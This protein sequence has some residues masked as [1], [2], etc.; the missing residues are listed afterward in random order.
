MCIDQTRRLLQILKKSNTIPKEMLDKLKSHKD[1]KD[2]KIFGEL[3]IYFLNGVTLARLDIPAS[4]TNITANK[5]SG[6][7]H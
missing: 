1:L 7:N 2:S 5:E 4:Y 6:N 3:F